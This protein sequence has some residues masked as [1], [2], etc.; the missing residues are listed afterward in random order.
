MAKTVYM[1]DGPSLDGA[2]KMSGNSPTP[3][4]SSQTTS[5]SGPGMGSSSPEQSLLENA[6]VSSMPVVNTLTVDTNQNGTIRVNTSVADAMPETGPGAS[7]RNSS[8]AASA[9]SISTVG[10]QTGWVQLGNGYKYIKED[11]GYKT[12]WHEENSADGKKIW[13][14][15]DEKP[16]TKEWM[17]TGWRRI[18][19][20]EGVL[21][22]YH[23]RVDGKMSLYWECLDGWW[24]YFEPRND[25]GYLVSDWYL[26]NNEYYY[27]NTDVDKGYMQLDWLK[28]RGKWYYFHKTDEKRGMMAHDYLMRHTDGNLY[29]LQEKSDGSMAVNKQ[30]VDHATGIV[31]EADENGICT[32]VQGSNDWLSNLK[33]DTSISLTSEKKKAMITAAS[34]LIEQKFELAFIAGVLGNIK[35]EGNIG[36]FESSNYVSSPGDKPDYLKYMDKFHNYRNDYSGQSIEGKSLSKLNSILTKFN[37]MKW[38]DTQEKS[39]VGFG[40]GCVQ[41]TFDRTY[42]LIGIYIEVAK[43]SDRIT[44]AQ[45]TEAEGIMVVRE[46]TGTYYNKVY[47]PWLNANQRNLDSSQAAYN[48]VYDV[49]MKYE[50]PKNANSKAP[51]RA[52]DAQVI[53]TVMKGDNCD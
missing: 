11:G 16:D 39:R 27:F 50:K 15:F 10:V 28:I 12:G 5:L 35:N 17:A 32:K 9:G 18:V 33:N 7:S 51:I 20:G 53:Y 34:V 22:W 19:N 30:I 36:M 37:N 49:C 46:L 24:Y 26:L 2:V 4:Y 45:A 3:A 8:A 43:G 25:A 38:Y 6:T 21:C 47:M 42:Q 44:E 41:W 40:L 1:S 31:Y 48:A 29:Y 13:Y 23:F 14:Y 52:K